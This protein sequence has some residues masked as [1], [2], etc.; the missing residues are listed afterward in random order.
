MILSKQ[1]DVSKFTFLVALLSRLELRKICDSF[2]KP[3]FNVFELIELAEFTLA[4]LRE[5]IASLGFPD[6]L[7]D[8]QAKL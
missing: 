8:I 7:R 2:F 5:F 1:F 4:R 3:A 6:S